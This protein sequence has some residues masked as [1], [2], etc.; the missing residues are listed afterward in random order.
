MDSDDKSA[1]TA[2]ESYRKSGSLLYWRN[3]GICKYVSAK[4][5]LLPELIHV[6]DMVVDALKELFIPTFQ[7]IRLQC[8]SIESLH[9]KQ[10][11]WLLRSAL[12]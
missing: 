1:I 10:I 8:R 6:L 5:L 3:Q 12:C 4:V 9:G 7:A 2:F 11:S